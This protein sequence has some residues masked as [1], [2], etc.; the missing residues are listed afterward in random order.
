MAILK[1]KIASLIQ[2]YP[3]SSC[4][5]DVVVQRADFSFPKGAANGDIIDLATIPAGHYLLGARIVDTSGSTIGSVAILSGQP[6]ADTNDDGSARTLSATSLY[7]AAGK[8]ATDAALALAPQP[9][10]QSIGVAMGAAVAANAGVLT[11]LLTYAQ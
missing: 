6:G 10:D 8:A 5:G 1:S 2:T 11:L 3:T 4:A 9:V 7:D